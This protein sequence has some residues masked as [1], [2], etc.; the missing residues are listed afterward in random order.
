MKI[1]EFSVTVKI[2]GIIYDVIMNM[3]F[4][5]MSSYYKSMSP[6][7]PAHSS[8][9]PDSVG[10]L[11]CD[12]SGFESLPYLICNHIII[13]FSAGIMLI[14][15]FGKS[16]LFLHKLG[17]T[18]IAAD[19]NTAICLLRILSIIRSVL[20]ALLNGFS[21]IHMHGYKSGRSYKSSPLFLNCSQPL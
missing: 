16:K 18:L 3:G 15:S 2:R 21:L 4:I 19:Q 7:S 13:I 20:Q 10:F 12:L 6:F 9:I 14:F 1:S 11:R 17:I 5:Y 8:F